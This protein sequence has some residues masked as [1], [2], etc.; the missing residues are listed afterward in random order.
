[1]IWDFLN[2]N[3][4]KFRYSLL[5]Y[6]FITHTQQWYSQRL[7]NSLIQPYHVAPPRECFV[8][9]IVYTRGQSCDQNIVTC[10]EMLSIWL[11]LSEAR[12]RKRY[13]YSTCILYF[14]NWF[15]LFYYVTIWFTRKIRSLICAHLFEERFIVVKYKIR[16]KSQNVNIILTSSSRSN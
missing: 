1:M 2:A 5:V 6:C 7:Y 10:T 15:L 12:R 11:R 16:T 14:V 4:Y 13:I 3:L 8:M 9:Q